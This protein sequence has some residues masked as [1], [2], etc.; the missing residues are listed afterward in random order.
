MTKS[1]MASVQDAPSEGR[2]QTKQT[3][4]HAQSEGT[5]RPRPTCSDITLG[6]NPGL[7][8]IPNWAVHE[9]GDV[10]TWF[11]PDYHRLPD[12]F[13]PDAPRYGRSCLTYS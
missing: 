3:D 6:Y 10:P 4:A 12:W 11:E 9:L 13:L 8:R 1:K 7:W 2:A 5:S